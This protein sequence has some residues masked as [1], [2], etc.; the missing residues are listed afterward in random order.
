[1][2]KNAHP[3]TTSWNN[4]SSGTKRIFCVK[5]MNEM[6]TNGITITLSQ[7]HVLASLASQHGCQPEV[8]VSTI[9]LRQ[10]GQQ[11][12]RQKIGKKKYL[13]KDH[14]QNYYCNI[15]S[16]K[17]GRFIKVSGQFW[18]IFWAMGKSSVLSDKNQPL[19]ALN[20]IILEQNLVNRTK[21][22]CQEVTKIGY[23]FINLEFVFLDYKP[24]DCHHTIQSSILLDKNTYSYDCG[25]KDIGTGHH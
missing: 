2:Q 13:E 4:I 15:L 16:R 3:H 14:N 24:F 1:M 17:W 8:P 7:E 25:Y 5:N 18:H 19:A 20:R 12:V 6:A 10:T 9:G 23:F 11:L 21:K 22:G